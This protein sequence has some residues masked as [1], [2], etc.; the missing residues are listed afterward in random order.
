MLLFA[1]TATFLYFQ[2]ARIVSHSFADRGAQTAFFA[3]VDLVVNCLTLL[4]QLFFTGRIVIL[5]GV[6]V[7]LALVAG[8]DHARFRCAGLRAEPKHYRRVPSTAPR[9]RLRDRASD[10][11]GALYRGAARGPLQDQGLYRYFCLSPGGPGRRLVCGSPRG[12]G[13]DGDRTRRDPDCRHLAGH[14]VVAR[15][16]S[17]SAGSGPRAGRGRPA[18]MFA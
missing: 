13:I 7:A 8:A 5:L 17:G 2:Q 10:P 1:I 16:P 6:G 12:P 4:V 18:P 15:P 11:R 9:R 3:T 14:R